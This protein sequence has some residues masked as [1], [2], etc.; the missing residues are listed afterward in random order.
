MNI[1]LLE[2]YLL[3][4]IFKTKYFSKLYIQFHF[5]PSFVYLICCLILLKLLMYPDIYAEA[6]YSS[7]KPQPP[8]LLN[9]RKPS[10]IDKKL[11]LLLF[12]YCRTPVQAVQKMLALYLGHDNAPMFQ[13]PGDSILIPLTDSKAR[14][15][16][17]KLSLL[18]QITPTLTFHMFRKGGTTWA[19]NH[20]VSIEN[21]MQ[22]GTWSSQAVWRYIKSVPTASSPVSRSFQHHLQP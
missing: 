11:K 12:H 5:F 7:L 17:K 21:I 15:H 8:Y 20:G 10:R 4:T 13:I 9:G 16:L 19:F 6:I 18:L 1:Y 2:L 22:H 3:A 14:K